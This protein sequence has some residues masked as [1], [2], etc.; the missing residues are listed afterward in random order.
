MSCTF[1]DQAEEFGLREHIS[2][3]R[4]QMLPDLNPSGPEKTLKAVET[5]VDLTAAAVTLMLDA[6]RKRMFDPE[7]E[8]KKTLMRLR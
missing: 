4:M 5:D 7:E 2:F 6:S 1:E 8:K 3:E